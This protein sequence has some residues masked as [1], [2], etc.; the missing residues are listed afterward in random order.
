MFKNLIKFS[1]II[2]IIFLSSCEN[3]KDVLFD[4]ISNTNL[5]KRPYFVCRDKLYVDENRNFTLTL[6]SIGTIQ[7]ATKGIIK[8]TFLPNGEIKFNTR[9]SFDGFTFEDNYEISTFE[10]KSYPYI[11]FKANYKN[12]LKGGYSTAFMD[13]QIPKNGCQQGY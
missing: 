8:G 6:Y 10:D 7:S 1:S 4:Q 12:N 5:Y 13:F 2:L 9:K 3:N 11:R